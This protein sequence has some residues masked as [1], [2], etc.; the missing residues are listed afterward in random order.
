MLTFDLMSPTYSFVEFLKMSKP[1]TEHS[2]HTEQNR[3][4]DLHVLVPSHLPV[5]MTGRHFT[6]TI[7]R[8]WQAWHKM[9]AAILGEDQTI[10]FFPLTFY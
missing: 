8:S 2:E 1:H 3:E 4:C 7:W 10:T 9:A 5:P 6:A